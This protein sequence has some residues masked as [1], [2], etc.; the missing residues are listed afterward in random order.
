LLVVVVLVVGV[1]RVQRRV[2]QDDSVGFAVAD[3]AATEANVAH[4]QVPGNGALLADGA[5]S[6]SSSAHE[7]GAG[8]ELLGVLVRPLPG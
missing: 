1:L 6:S 5:S 2:N 8:G 4:R 7:V 3:Q